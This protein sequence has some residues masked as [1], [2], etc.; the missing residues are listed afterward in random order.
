MIKIILVGFMLE[1][2]TSKKDI[3]CFTVRAT[4]GQ[5]F[6]HSF[7]AFHSQWSE[8]ID[9]NLLRFVEVYFMNKTVTTERGENV[10]M[11]GY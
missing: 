10:Q 4:Y 9:F 6:I 1:W 7:N 11:I 5:S 3:K 2:S 8:N